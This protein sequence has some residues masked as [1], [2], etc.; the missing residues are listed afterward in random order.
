MTANEFKREVERDPAESFWLK[1]ALVTAEG[2]DPIDA[3]ND[4]E[5]LL[6]FCKLRLAE[7]IT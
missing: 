5:T 3:M 7:A 2:R 4:A 6:F 1:K